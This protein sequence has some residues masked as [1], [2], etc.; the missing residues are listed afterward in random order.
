LNARLGIVMHHHRPEVVEFGSRAI[1]WCRANGVEPSLP[2]VDA[3]LVDEA[4]L[5]VDADEFGGGL[6][7]LLSLGGDGTMLRAVR[8]AA[9][10]DVPV[11]GVNAGQLG[12]L[13]EVDPTRL[14]ET[15]DA[16]QRGELAE[17]DRMLLEVEFAGSTE[18]PK[19]WALNEVVLERAESGHVVSVDATIGGEHF[20]RYLADGLIVA[21]PTGSTAYSLSAGGPIVEP[22]FEALVV[23][24]VAAHMV[25]D[26]SLVLKPSTEVELTVVGYRNGV[27]TIDGRQI[28][29]LTPGETL[30]CRASDRRVKFLTGGELNFHRILK[31]KFGLEDR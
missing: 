20:T 4:E 26:R 13:T 22:D 12:Y 15:L 28:A 3:G 19:A 24:P 1:G 11:L 7:A 6:D 27:V 29:E 25:F 30:V 14:E 16:W 9:P 17:E 2:K 5:G 31:D 18:R 23:T 8:F 21:T 10:H